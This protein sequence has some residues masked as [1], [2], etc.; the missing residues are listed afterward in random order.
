MALFTITTTAAASLPPDQVGSLK[1]TIS[2]ASTNVF[3][4]NDFTTNASPNY[5][6][7]QGHSL[8][9][10][11]ID[12]LT[13]VGGAFKLNSVDILVGDEI[14]KLD[15]K[16]GLLQFVDDGS[17]ITE[18]TSQFTYFASDDVSN[19]FSTVTGTIT[20]KTLAQVNE[21]PVIGDA[22]QTLAYG[23]TL[24]FTEAMFTTDTVPAYSDSE[25]DTADI[26][27]ITSLPTNGT[28]KY[29]GKPVYVNQ[30]ITFSDIASGNLTF[31]GPTGFTGFGSGSFSFEIADS[32]GAYSDNNF[33]A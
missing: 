2:H 26:L 23:L 7:P 10:I 9:K 13:N 31:V 18:H 12:T 5:S 33:N 29:K 28:V 21:G 8:S 19:T 4:E 24:T 32:S 17:D 22:T 20:V 27:K 11:K 3:T 16:S 30:E 14:D 15:I 6:H 25:G 1:E